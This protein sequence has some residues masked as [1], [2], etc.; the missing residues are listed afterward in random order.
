MF[1]CLRL[2]FF[3][4]SIFLKLHKNMLKQF[5]WARKS[6]RFFLAAHSSCLYKPPNLQFNHLCDALSQRR[7]KERIQCR[8]FYKV[9]NPKFGTVVGWVL[10]LAWWSQMLSQLICFF[11]IKPSCQGDLLDVNISKLGLLRLG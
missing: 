5:P 4:I 7:E 1:D 11:N 8:F 2:V 3:T 9:C 6:S 10:V